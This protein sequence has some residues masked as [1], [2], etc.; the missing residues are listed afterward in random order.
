MDIGQP[1]KTVEIPQER[2]ITL[3][4]EEPKREPVPATPPPQREEEAVPA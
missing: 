4:R 2:P 3:P 1:V